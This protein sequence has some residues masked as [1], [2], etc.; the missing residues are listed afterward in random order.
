MSE[1][2]ASDGAPSDDDGT[3][4]ASLY[5]GGPGRLAEAASRN[6]ESNEYFSSSSDDNEESKEEEDEDPLLDDLDD[7][8]TPSV[9]DMMK[10]LAN[11]PTYLCMREKKKSRVENILKDSLVN[12]NRMPWEKFRQDLLDSIQEN[13]ATK[14]SQIDARKANHQKNKSRL[15]KELASCNPHEFDPNTREL[16][17]WTSMAYRLAY[18][19]VQIFEHRLV[20]GDTDIYT[21]VPELLKTDSQID[22]DFDQW[23]KEKV[24]FVAGWLSFAVNKKASRRLKKVAEAIKVFSKNTNISRTDA[25]GY[26]E[27]LPIRETVSTELYD[28]LRY[29]SFA[30]YIFVLRIE[31]VYQYFL[32]G[33]SIS[34]Y[35]PR[36]IAYLNDALI[37]ELLEEFS[38]KFLKVESGR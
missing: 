20:Y 6:D 1:E 11:H 33:R 19:F 37:K 26:G 5:A 10:A 21:K 31:K 30:F 7:G 14:V 36:V 12:E 24:Y 15:Y 9:R 17:E 2:D 34:I 38:D 8:S 3:F 32:T 22:V 16:T 25:V 18:L 28:G 27:R 29:V 4:D 13:R 35:G 23:E